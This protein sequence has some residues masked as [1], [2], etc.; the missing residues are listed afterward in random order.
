MPTVYRLIARDDNTVRQ[1]RSSYDASIFMLGRSLS[2]YI[3]IKSD[4]M[5]DRVILWPM[6]PS[7]H[8]IDE[9]LLRQ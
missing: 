7:I 6:D 4:D 8:A 5:G 3:A 1:F 9:A 2:A